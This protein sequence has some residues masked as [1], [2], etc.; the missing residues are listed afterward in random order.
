MKARIILSSL[1]I[2][3]ISSVTV[4]SQTEKPLQA[5][6]GSN[7]VVEKGW[8]LLRVFLTNGTS[9]KVNSIYTYQ[10]STV[11][12]TSPHTFK[13]WVKIKDYE[14]P[15][16]EHKLY[17]LESRCGKREIRVLRIVEH[18]K[19][20]P[21]ETLSSPDYAFEDIEPDSLFDMIYSAVCKDHDPPS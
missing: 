19:K 14:E 1:F 18:F 12:K 3:A 7:V 5:I 6:D 15:S 13:F 4:F 2:V 10:T 11:I 8:K 21:S 17:L 16:I 9:G 20:K